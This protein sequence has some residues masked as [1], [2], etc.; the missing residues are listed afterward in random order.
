LPLKTG[1]SPWGKRS[2]RCLPDAN[3]GRP[4]E[5]GGRPRRQT[6]VGEGGRR[7]RGTGTP[8]KEDTP[9]QQCKGKG[10][11]KTVSEGWGPPNSGGTNQKKLGD[12]KTQQSQ[13]P[14]AGWGAKTQWK[15]KRRRGKKTSKK[16]SE[17]ENDSNYKK[18]TKEEKQKKRRQMEL[19][20]GC[21]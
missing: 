2:R 3:A 14:G 1:R 12:K 13:N 17:K 21:K 6:R 5:C 9:R 10:E 20:R 15:G 11:K 19:T 4:K 7:A 8:E 18:G 16:L